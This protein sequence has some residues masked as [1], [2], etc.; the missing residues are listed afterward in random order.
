MIF[1]EW[2]RVWAFAVST[3]LPPAAMNRPRM[4]CES[5][6]LDPH[7]QSSPKVIAPSQKGLTA[8]PER[9]RVT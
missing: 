7:P 9:P 4:A 1:S 6:T 3:K 5:E 2:P 8:R